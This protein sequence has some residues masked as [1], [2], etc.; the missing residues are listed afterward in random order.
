MSKTKFGI[1]STICLLLVLI[2]TAAYA[3]SN[4]VANENNNG[5]TIT[6]HKGD[7]ITLTLKENPSTGYAWKLITTAGLQI[8]SDKYVPPKSSVMGATGDHIWVTRAIGT[9]DQQIK[10]EYKR[11]RETKPI[12]TFILNVKVLGSGNQKEYDQGYKDG[13]RDG[14]RDGFREGKADSKKPASVFIKEKVSKSDYDRGYEKGYSDCFQN[15]YEAGLKVK[16]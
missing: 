8:V 5:N 9:G 13:C 16:K 12:K 3:A 14:Y 7:T 11:S 10:G 6:V 4:T 2:P 15:G 1:I